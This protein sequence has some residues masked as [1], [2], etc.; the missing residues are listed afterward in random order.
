MT[1]WLFIGLFLLKELLLRALYIAERRLR[2]EDALKRR[3]ELRA[4][5]AQAEE[6]AAEDQGPAIPLDI[7][8]VDFNQLSDQTRRL[9]SAGFLFGAVLGTWAIWSDV[10]PALGFLNQTALPF[11]STRIV[12]GVAK[13]VPVTLGDLVVG[14]VIVFITVLAARNLPGLL[15]I[16]LLQRLPLDPGARYA[17][18]SLSQYTIA[19]IGIFSAFSSIGLE[20]SKLQ[21]LVAAL[22]VGLG[23]GLQEIVANFVSGIILLFERP[24]RIGDVITVDGNSGVVSR[25]R[26]RATTITNWDK[27]ELLVPN[28]QF[29]TGK[30]INWTLSNKLNRIVITIGVAYGSDVDRALELMSEAADE[31]EHVLADPKPMTSFEGFGDN[32]LT[33][34]LRCYLDTLDYRLATITAMHRALNRKFNEAGIAIAFPQRDLHLDTTKPLEININ[35]ARGGGQSPTA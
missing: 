22:G 15:E 29:I 8:E 6:D 27:Q 20:W 24:I 7:P 18:T 3:E 28:K 21:W 2:L 23:F 11:E 19:G 32:A 33:L 12:D 4:Q 16:T 5:R 30:L 13:Q 31:N 26:I 1:L 25:I 17:I 9:V 34:L 14:L 35:R 10:L